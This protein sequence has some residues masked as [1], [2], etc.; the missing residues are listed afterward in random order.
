MA[1][2][3]EPSKVDKVRTRSFADQGIAVV[4]RRTRR[5]YRFL[6]PVLV[7]LG[8]V[9]G[10]ACQ[11]PTPPPP[12]GCSITLPGTGAALSGSGRADD[13]HSTPT[14]AVT[15]SAAPW[16]AHDGPSRGN[17]PQ[18]AFAES[19]PV[20]F[21]TLEVKITAL[22]HHLATRVPITRAESQA[23]STF[24]LEVDAKCRIEIDS[25]AA[26]VQLTGSTV[27][28]VAEAKITGP[29][30]PPT[31]IA[32][33][34][35]AQYQFNENSTG[36]LDVV[37]NGRSV[38]TITNPPPGASAPSSPPQFATAP[39]DDIGPIGGFTLKAG[40]T[41]T[42]VFTLIAEGMS[43]NQSN[44]SPSPPSSRG[45]LDAKAVVRLVP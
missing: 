2:R 21:D 22:T 43:L 39:G 24:T 8:A 36:Q 30:T 28:Y 40:T 32:A 41:Y 18:Q 16:F 14:R 37:K 11:G 6:S 31:L 35:T 1:N 9:F 29:G 23:T 15:Y 34:T 10:S 12:P 25:E 45:R 20:K 42:L 4:K 38:K 33:L 44:P 7:S 17:I 26:L 27:Q 13:G 19:K 3:V 5:W